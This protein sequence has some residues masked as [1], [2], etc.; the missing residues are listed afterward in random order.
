MEL[1]NGTISS[2]ENLACSHCNKP[3]EI[4]RIQTKSDC[5]NKPIVANYTYDLPFSKEVLTSRA[6]NM[7][8]YREML[9]VFH[10]EN[11]ITLGE[12]MTPML[13]WRN[14]GD[15][16]GFEHLL[17]KDEGLNPTGSFKARGLSMAI[18]KAKEF[19]VK[20]CVIPTAGN[21]GGA[22]SAYCA[23]ASMESTVIMPKGTPAVY[24]EESER[25][26]AKVVLCDGLIDECG[27]M[28]AQ[29]SKDTG[30]FNM[31]TLKEPYR[32]EGK[33]TMGY[34]IAEQL[35]WELPDVIV[36]PTGGGTG[37]IGIWR[38]FQEMIRLGWIPG[39]RLP[40]MIAVQSEVCSP[41]A[42]VFHGKKSNGPF[43]M[44]IANGLSVP[45]AF[46]LDLI[47]QT[48]RQSKGTVVTVS[49]QQILAGMSEIGS[50]EG[51]F[52]SPEGAAVWE[53]LKLMRNEG[54]VALHEKIVLLNTGNGFKYAEHFH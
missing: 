37:L 41:L 48:I 20:S 5:C 19:G 3:H 12:G 23:I 2:L 53:A 43:R 17:V 45:V 10:D 1:L 50:T 47:L 44:S 4:D 51:V 22:M 7:W 52:I 34:E 15:Q 32:L 33:K 26:G 18:S 38:A 28:A 6:P 54:T 14:L 9:P 30:A 42:T 31:S 46:G 35:N 24:K 40:R 21:A 11:I 36:Y 39:D 29:I 27:K 13:R 49:E 16:Y 25:H 8:R